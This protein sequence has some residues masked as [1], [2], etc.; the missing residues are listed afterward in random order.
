[1]LTCVDVDLCSDSWALMLRHHDRGR[2]RL[3]NVS[4]TGADCSGFERTPK[5]SRR[6]VT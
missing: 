3:Q 4:N 2:I 1:M 5:N 6:S